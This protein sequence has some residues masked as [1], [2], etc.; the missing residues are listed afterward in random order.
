MLFLFQEFCK[1]DYVFEKAS[2]QPQGAINAIAG[3]ITEYVHI[4]KQCKAYFAMQ[5]TLCAGFKCPRQV[6]YARQLPLLVTL[7]AG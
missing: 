6:H 3:T 4:L 7:L 5:W 1:I 2:Q